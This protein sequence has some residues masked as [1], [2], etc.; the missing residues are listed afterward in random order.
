MERQTAVVR[1]IWSGTTLSSSKVIGRLTRKN[2]IP[3]K[4]IRL[5]EDKNPKWE[6]KDYVVCI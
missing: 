2:V 5:T 4:G 6:Y 3:E 1:E